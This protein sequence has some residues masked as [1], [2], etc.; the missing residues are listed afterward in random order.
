[1][2][3]LAMNDDDRDVLMLAGLLHSCTPQKINKES[4]NLLQPLAVP[5]GQSRTDICMS[6]LYQN[7]ASKT[8]DRTAN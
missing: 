1:M 3:R 2:Q 7:I 6:I 8:R 5:R 4:I